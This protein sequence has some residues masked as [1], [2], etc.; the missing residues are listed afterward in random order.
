MAKVSKRLLFIITILVFVIMVS[1][2][3]SNGFGTVN[4]D[5]NNLESL[6]AQAAPD[7]TQ[8]ASPGSANVVVP[9][10]VVP[11][12]VVP[13]VQ[14]EP[15]SLQYWLILMYYVN[16]LYYFNTDIKDNNYDN[17]LRVD[18]SKN[19]GGNNNY[20]N[21][22]NDYNNMFAYF[23]QSLNSIQSQ[24]QQQTQLQNKQTMTNAINTYTNTLVP[25]G[26]LGY[27]RLNGHINILKNLQTSINTHYNN[28][29]NYGSL[30]TT[31]KLSSVDFDNVSIILK[32]IPPLQ[33]YNGN[34]VRNYFIVNCGIKK[35]LFGD[36][37]GTYHKLQSTPLFSYIKSK[38]LDNVNKDNYL[39]NDADLKTCGVNV[40]KIYTDLNSGITDLKSMNAIMDTLNNFGSCINNMSYKNEFGCKPYTGT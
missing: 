11:N 21:N 32:D 7:T 22:S 33:Q 28:I 25:N 6:S 12:V 9:N 16:I 38:L 20:S 26:K 39:K 34:V 24:Q 29:I 15:D 37:S 13:V 5:G 35:I 19:T 2:V 31:T 18:Y 36:A 27:L 1:L 10:V 30:N 8:N 40:S 3:A 4:W 23:K 17:I 14:P